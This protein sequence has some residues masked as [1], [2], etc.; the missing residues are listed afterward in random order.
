MKNTDRRWFTRRWPGLLAILLVCPIVTAA[1]AFADASERTA[2]RPAPEEWELAGDLDSGK[3]IYKQYCQKCHGKRGNGQGIMAR[4][5]EPK[6]RDFTDREVMSKRSD[7]EIYLGIREG[8]DPVGLSDQ[9]TAWE[10]TLSEEEIMDV[11]AYLRQF[12]EFDE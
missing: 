11:A 8:G 10:D 4:D 2:S 1:T 5:L 12:A 9:M 7:W 6:P 3:T